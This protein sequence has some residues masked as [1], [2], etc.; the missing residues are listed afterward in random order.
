MALAGMMGMSYDWT[1]A[2]GVD[3]AGDAVMTEILY[4][5]WSW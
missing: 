1:M 2:V 3:L 4:N 5:N